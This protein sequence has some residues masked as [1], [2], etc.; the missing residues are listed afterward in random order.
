MTAS[1]GD[2][3]RPG[4]APVRHWVLFVLGAIGVA[5]VIMPLAFGMFAKAPK[6]AV[7]IAGFKPYMTT[8]RLQRLPGRAAPDQRR[9][10]A[11]RHK[12][13]RD[14]SAG[15]RQTGRP[16]ARSIPS[17]FVRPAMAGHRLEDDRPHVRGGGK[18]RQ[19]RGCGGVAEFHALSVVLRDPGRARCRLC[20]RRAGPPGSRAPSAVGYSSSSGSA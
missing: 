3:E 10:A 19:L 5:L 15:A 18:P 8:A 6:G 1:A 11:D 14:I 20:H 17:S 16:S 4:D 12:C 9:R 7:M 2:H 13:G